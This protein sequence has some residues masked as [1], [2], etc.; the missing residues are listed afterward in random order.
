MDLEHLCIS[1][2]V[3]AVCVSEHW[4]REGEVDLCTPKGFVPANV[5]CRH[6]FK[7]GGVGIFLK[8]NIEFEVIDLSAYFAELHC[9]VACV[10]LASNKLVII[11]IYRSPA[12][13]VN[14][15]LENFESIIKKILSKNCSYKIIIGGDFNIEMAN[16]TT[17]VSLTFL[18]L[19]RSYNFVCSNKNPTRNKACIDNIIVNFSKDLYK[20]R[21]LG[22]CFAD[23]DP[24]LLEVTVKINKFSK[25]NNNN[26]K[27]DIYIRTQSNNQ[28][29]DFSE[30]LV[31]NQWR[32]ATSMLGPGGVSD[33]QMCD[34]FFKMYIDLWHSC[35]PLIKCKSDHKNISKNKY[36]KVKWYNAE[37]ADSRTLMLSYYTMYKRMVPGTTQ[38][39]Q[40]Y[41][42]YL[43]LKKDYKKQ[44]A[45]AKKLACQNYIENSANK[46]KAAW[47][48]ISG[49]SSP[50]HTH[51]VSLEPDVFNNYFLNSVRD[52]EQ[53]FD[54]STASA[55]NLLLNTNLIRPSRFNWKMIT[56]D[57]V[58]KTAVQ[59][60]NS[61]AM[62]CY[63]LSNNIIKK[64]I[65]LISMPLAFVL[66][67]CFQLGYFPE[68][69][70]LSKVVPIFKKGDKSLPQNYRPV[71]IVPIFSKLFESII[72]NQLREYFERNNFISDSQFGFRKGMS[73]VTAVQQIVGNSIEAFENKETVA[74]TLFDLTKAFD[75][76][77]FNILL[78][79][80]EFYGM[81]N[82]SL[83]LI[84]SYLSNRTQYVALNGRSSAVASISTGVPQGSV[85]GP[86]LFIVAIND[87]P[88]NNSANTVIYADDTTIMKSHKDL[89]YL[90]DVIGSSN[91][92]VLKWFHSNKLHCNNGKTQNLI[93]SLKNEIPYNSVKLL[94]IHIDSKLCWKDQI[95]NVCKKISRT[96][97]LFWKLKPLVNLEYLRIAYFGLFQ[98]HITYG[99]ILWGHSHYVHD[100]LLIQKKIIRNMAGAGALEHC[101]PLFI[102]LKIC[103]IIN[104][105][106]FHVLMYAKEN[107]NSFQQRF[108]IHNHNT[109]NRIN[110]DIP[111]HRLAITGKSYKINSVTFFNRLPEMAWT[112]PHNKFKIV[113]YN[114][115][116][117]NPFY[118]INEFLESVIDITF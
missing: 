16:P 25:R 88:C 118:S 13:N 89:R 6:I 56:P 69:L 24:L 17:N 39:N 26:V 51:Q 2:S 76:V 83:N 22:G 112:A 47:E 97:F 115:L 96:V 19:L 63:W 48:V 38:Y 1:E 74:L 45:N 99:L 8:N 33:T 87:L 30:C 116:L 12:G 91:R 103:T 4:L 94:G 82:H 81:D 77:P 104:L 11:G 73:T 20:S 106:I 95:D 53:Q 40:A 9:E 107:L 15:F 111:H 5:L 98:S 57:E 100:I 36:N 31:N 35:S 54:D 55:I 108:N 71:S 75:C 21:V 44:L 52:L 29:K 34:Q 68:P 109:R 18:N 28:I 41:K 59:L 93:L 27:N 78:D 101:K 85:L 62:D 67:T 114:W 61:K 10:R 49:E 80:L 90:N 32:F 64:T 37:L 72:Y 42:I 117:K 70:K 65:H 7:N 43:N 105:Y 14:V 113:I 60:S 92:D 110:L 84:K 3:D 46:C 23:H 66:N 50:A 58:V 86:F 79:K 102:S